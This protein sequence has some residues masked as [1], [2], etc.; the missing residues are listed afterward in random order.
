MRSAELK[1]VH[2]VCYFSLLFSMALS[3]CGENSI[4]DVNKELMSYMKQLEH[5][6]LNCFVLSQV[7]AIHQFKKNYLESSKY[8]YKSYEVC[9]KNVLDLFQS[10][11]SLYFSGKEEAGFNRMQGAI[12]K[13]KEMKDTKMEQVLEKEFDTLQKFHNKGREGHNKGTPML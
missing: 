12:E 4:G 8:Y 3:G 11:L 10:G 9:P 5:D 1:V 13:A 2:F 6:P 7:G